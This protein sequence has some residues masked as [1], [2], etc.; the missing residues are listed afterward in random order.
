MASNGNGS[1]TPS[2]SS[3]WLDVY[4]SSLPKNVSAIDSNVISS[5]VVDSVEPRFV[6]S[7]QKFQKSA[8]DNAAQKAAAS[9]ST[10]S[11]S[12]CR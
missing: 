8:M 6:V 5:P 10:R 7:R 3:S 1:G 12:S 9:R 11:S 2:L 4:G